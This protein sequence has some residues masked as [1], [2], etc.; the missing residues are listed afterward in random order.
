MKPLILAHVVINV[1][2]NYFNMAAHTAIDFP[3]V[4]A[5]RKTA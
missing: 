1:F 3:R 2:T 4:E 5:A